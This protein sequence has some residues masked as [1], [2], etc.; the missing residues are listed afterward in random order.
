MKLVIQVPCHNEQANLGATLAALPRELPGFESVYVVVLDDGSSD[1]T[2]AIA[3][4]AGVRQVV[5][6]PGQQG[7]ARSFL[8][9]LDASLRLGADVIVNTDGDNQYPA[10]SIGE[11]VRPI[12]EHRADIVIGNRGPGELAHFGFTKRWLSRFGSWVVG[13]AAGAAIPDA[14]S[15]FR[16]MSRAAAMRL[17]VVSEFTYTHETIIQAS[18]SRMA[19]AHVPI[20]ARRTLRKSRLAAGKW[21]YIASS[22]GA[23]ARTYAMYQPLRAFISVAVTLALAGL[24]LSLRFVYFFLTDVG[25]GHV[26]SLLFAAL[27]LFSGFVC[28]L[29]GILADL[30]AANRRLLEEVLWR[31]RELEVRPAVA[32]EPPTRLP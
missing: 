21:S 24:V 1:E 8:R 2:A 15:G 16:A 17:V 19:I 32:Y 9:G 27:L 14:A 23:I 12:V 20:V 10:A 25:R 28:G 6:T 31:V 26:Q 5:S 22:A 13:A 29:V 30:V 4:S 11:L 7:L 3:R 18:R